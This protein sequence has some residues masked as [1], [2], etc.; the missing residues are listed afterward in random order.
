MAA[1]DKPI[2]KYPVNLPDAYID[3]IVKSIIFSVPAQAIYIF[4][5]YARGEEHPDSDIDLYVIADNRCRPLTYGAII[6][7]TLLWML[8]AKDVLCGTQEMFDQ[9]KQDIST[10][11]YLIN[12]EGVKIY[13]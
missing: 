7:R 4:G 8:Q 12:K 9:R 10:V 13:G 5:S 11:E 3:R 2:K 1:L 6:R